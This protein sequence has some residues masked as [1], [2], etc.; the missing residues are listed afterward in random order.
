MKQRTES[1]VCYGQSGMRRATSLRHMPVIPAIISVLLTLCTTSNAQ[2]G[3]SVCVCSPAVY[4]MTFN[5]SQTCNNTIINGDGIIT[6]DC[7]I[8]PF[9]DDNVTDLVPIS[10]GSID[11]IELD[12]DLELLTQSSQF[13]T[14]S[15]GDTITYTSISNVPSAINETVY[16]IAFQVS[17]IGNNAA[18]DTLFF[19]GLIVYVTECTVF[20]VI[21]EGSSIGWV[22]FVSSNV[23]LKPWQL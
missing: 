8:A 3:T 13:G 12:A 17:V 2:I 11:I 4:E 7:A 10:V 19:A 9:Q 18:G 6:T 22:A 1:R 16:P 20:P 21:L 14:F 23:P 15:D 5:F